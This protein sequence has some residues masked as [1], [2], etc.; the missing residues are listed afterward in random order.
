MVEL[1]N[2]ILESIG[3]TPMVR[4]NRVTEGLAVSV[5]AKCEFLNP[6]GSVK[7][8][9][10]LELVEDAE[11]RGLLRPG[12][13]LV[14]ATSGNTGV[15]LAMVASLK[16]YQTVFVLPDKVSDE[17][18]RT[19]RAFGARVVT[20]PTDVAPEDPRSY[21]SV[22]RRIAGEI[23]GAFYVNQ[24]HNPANPLAHYKSTGP[25]IWEQTDGA[26]SALI[27]GMGTGG[28]IS[29]CGRY[30]K[31]RDPRVRV[32]GVDPDGSL[33]H[34]YI[35]HGRVGEAS[36]YRIEGIGEDFFPSTMDFS[37]VDD[38]VRVQDREAFLM[39][40]RLL[41]EEG[42][43]VG[44]SSGAVVAGALR[45]AAG[46]PA[47][48]RLVIIL[49]DGGSKYLSKVW[50][51][52]WMQAAGFLDGADLIED[53]L[54]DGP[55][56]R[57]VVLARMGEPISEVLRRMKQHSMDELPVVDGERVI[58]IVH[59]LDLVKQMLEGHRAPTDAINDLVSER[60]RAVSPGDS[61]E[62]LP[63]IFYN[64][65]TALVLEEGVLRGM[66]TPGDLQGYLAGKA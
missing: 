3:R 65:R 9:I 54:E 4:L 6:G 53:L 36:Q 61:I 32:I 5:Y 22:S 30:L 16:G 60:F 57:E 17:K 48:E 33:Y 19:L 44:I 55:S 59:E 38:V 64:S 15:G 66:L 34:D 42:L 47:D 62:R 25:E 2:S 10:A 35:K 23:P 56:P 27:V 31:E 52:G 29:G 49:P 21:Y 26:I 7:D 63:E 13:T 28:T 24:Y 46:R 14:E 11:R 43:F 8:R 41:A 20:T 1:R 45:Y 50:N 37:V 51:D 39:T 18:I 58:G 40:R 12:G